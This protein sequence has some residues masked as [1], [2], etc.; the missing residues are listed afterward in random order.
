MT[1]IFYHAHC[2]DGFAAAFAA[3]LVFGDRPGVQYLPVSY[4]QPVP[5]LAGGHGKHTVYILDFS[6]PRPVL[7]ALAAREDVEAVTVI[8]HHQTSAADLEGIPWIDIN[9]PQASKI[10][11]FFEMER[12]GAVLAW[13][14]FHDTTV[15]ELFRYVQDRDLWQWKLPNSRAIS[16][17]LKLRKYRNF[18]SWRELLSGWDDHIK[19]RL[20]LEGSAIVEAEETML[21]SLVALAE[22]WSDSE[23]RPFVRCNS[24]VLQSELGARLLLEF[25][26]AHYADIWSE[27]RGERR[28]SLRSRRIENVDVSAIAKS[29]GGG[30]HRCAAGYTEVLP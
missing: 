30:G 9:F 21:D 4:G 25:P 13:L 19:P 16:A 6:W 11:A 10:R 7:E 2:A 5:D 3:W 23:G 17:A 24:P 28:H 12:S 26:D 8:D 18:D 20:V 29:H 15:P 1:T 22:T 27:C 14:H